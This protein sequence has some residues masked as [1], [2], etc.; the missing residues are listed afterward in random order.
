MTKT[1]HIQLMS[2]IIKNKKSGF[3]LLYAILLTSVV[4]VVGVALINII[5]RQLILTS[6]NRNS[7][8]AYYNATALRNCIDFYDSKEYFIQTSY[9][10]E[11]NSSKQ[12]EQKD[13]VKCFGNNDVSLS[14]NSNNNIYKATASLDLGLGFASLDYAL[15]LDFLNQEEDYRTPD[16]YNSTDGFEN[17][18]MSTIVVKGSNS[19]LGASNS[20]TV[21]RAT[22]SIR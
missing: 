12:V 20:R 5:T 13:S 15:N 1:F 22:V 19:P 8:I 17:S 7:Q 21:V 2:L 9:D 18:C 3:A 14:W 16:C 4:L 10:P 6:L 11:G